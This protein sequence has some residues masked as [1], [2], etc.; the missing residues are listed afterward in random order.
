MIKTKFTTESLNDLIEMMY[1]FED[2]LTIWS[3][4]N[5]SCT[6]DVEVQIG[7]YEYFIIV[8][9]ENEKKDNNSGKLEL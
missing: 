1:E 5:I 8:T 7:N 4:K 3:E 6:W 2:K 9:V